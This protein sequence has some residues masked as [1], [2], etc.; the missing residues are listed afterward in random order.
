MLVC[1]SFICFFAVCLGWLGLARSFFFFFFVFLFWT[2]VEEVLRG[3]GREI[4][5]WAHLLRLAQLAIAHQHSRDLMDDGMVAVL[6]LVMLRGRRRHAE[7][8]AFC[9]A[10]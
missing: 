1:L 3:G 4:K 6:Q 7:L 8:Q 9:D 10:G 2:S 5:V